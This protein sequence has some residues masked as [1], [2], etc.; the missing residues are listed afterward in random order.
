MIDRSSLNALAWFALAAPALAQDA[1]RSGPHSALPPQFAPVFTPY[2]TSLFA[3]SSPGRVAVVFS[4]VATSTTSDVPGFPGIKFEPGSGTTNFDRPWVSPNGLHYAIVC[5]T[6]HAATEDEVLLVD[7]AVVGREG[8]PAPWVAGQN[9]G[10][11][12]TR[13]GIDDAG[14]YVFCTNIAPGTVNDDYVIHVT[15]G[16]TYNIF[17]QESLPVGAPVPGATWDDNIDSAILTSA[18]ISVSDDGIDG[19]G[20]TTADDEIIVLGSTL[21]AREGVTVPAG[22][23]LGG[24]NAW[25]N[26]D[27]ED[28]WINAAGTSVLI[29]G[30]LLGATTGD[31]VLVLNGNVVLQEGQIIPGS[32]F[33][34]PIAADG[35][36]EVS[37]DQGGNW[38]ARGDNTG[39]IDWVVRNG[40]VVA[41]TDQPIGVSGERIVLRATLDGAQEVP[42]TGSTATGQGFF[43]VDTIANTLTYR[44]TYT[45]FTNV[46]QAAHIHGFAPAGAN[47]GVLYTLPLGATKE[48]V[49]TYAESE[50]E[51]ILT[52]QTYVNVHSD[53]FPGGEIRGQIL[54]VP[55]AWDDATFADCFFAHTGNSLGDFVVGGVT[56]GPVSA[57][58]VVV[59]YSGGNRHVILREGDPCDLDGNGLYDDGLFF[60]TFGNDDL[61]LLDDG[62]LLFTA[63]LRDGAGV[64]TAQGLFRRLGGNLA[65]TLCYGD[66]SGAACPCGNASPVGANT[67]CVN[68]LGLG[69]KLDIA[70]DARITADTLVLQG[71]GMPNSSALYFQGTTVSGGGLGVP[72][73]D[74]LRCAA[75]TVIRLRTLTNTSNSSSYPQ[76]GDPSVSVKGLVT[77]PGSRVYQVWYRNADPVFCTPSTFNLTNGGLVTWGL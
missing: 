45:G 55:E 48:G 33:V 16:P 50:E 32:A 47:A 58:G 25:E 44:I 57:N 35:I 72:F 29:K 5:N 51:G 10:V 41:E 74:G 61:Q 20:V 67:G 30:D 63:T 56:N 26:F 62:S 27:L 40:T 7:G 69:G 17:A 65:R 6:T 54:Q 4:N 19:G 13:V 64:A 73:G 46:E 22:Q 76:S 49:I 71:S 37:M 59:L 31:D 9:W 15:P 53:V 3:S 18:G 60:N 77:A 36:L 68:S 28:T 43:L 8:T 75:G 66:G 70:G 24:A 23:A 14:D 42:P 34:N 2:G 38:Y 21:I 11:I 52:G 39:S 12:D 1:D